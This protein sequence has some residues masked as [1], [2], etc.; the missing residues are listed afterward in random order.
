M[1]I[2]NI[3][4]NIQSTKWTLTD[5]FEFSFS[6]PVVHLNTS[7]GLS[8]QDVWDMCV[9]NI[10]TPQLTAGIQESVLGGTRR[11][12]SQRF[13]LF[14]FSVTFRDVAGLELKEYF[15]DIWIKQQTYYFDEIK[16]TVQLTSNNK[17]VFKSQDCFV[18]DISQSQFDNGNNQILEFTVTFS[19][20]YYSNSK[21]Q[22]FGAPGKIKM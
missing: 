20:P 4:N 5:D 10:D 8:P 6:N 2:S 19:A 11:F 3:L 16:S 7:T 22:D 9:I 14:N 15:T 1:G 21:I 17:I 12:Y 13:Q 18:N